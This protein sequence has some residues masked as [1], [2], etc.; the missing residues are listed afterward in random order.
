MS[1]LKPGDRVRYIPGHAHGDSGHPDCEDG[2]V[3]SLNR[4]GFP[5]VV[6]DNAVRGV[7]DTLQK[8]ERWTAACTDPGDLMPLPATP[9]SSDD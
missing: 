1:D 3:R 8:A 6:Y 5:F 7:L 9:E 4:E 2:I